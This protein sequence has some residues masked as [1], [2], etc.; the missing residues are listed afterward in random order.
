M[1]VTDHITDIHSVPTLVCG[2]DGPPLTE[3]ETVNDVLSQ[4]LSHQADLVTIPVARAGAG[5]FELR[6]G[7]AG[8]VLQ[9]FANYRLRV[10]FIGDLS[11]ELT[12]SRPLRDF[13]RESNE[14]SQIWFI[15][16]LADLSARLGHSARNEKSL[17]S[18]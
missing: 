14:G 17:L 2:N 15:A 10:A 9:K 16:T 5:F 8:E 3:R 11:A 6:N 4:A 12:R 7:I 13:V 1:I 18:H